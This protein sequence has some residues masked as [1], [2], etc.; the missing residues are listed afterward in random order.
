MEKKDIRK[1]ILLL[2]E[3]LS[4]EESKE[5]SEKICRKLYEM[6]SLRQ[7]EII[8]GYMPIRNEVDIVPLL[9]KL[10][11]EG[12]RLA[13]PRVSGDRM[14]FY[15]INSLQDVVEGSFHVLEP[16]E[17]CRKMEAAGLVLIPGVA[18]D[19]KGG[20]IGYGKGYYDKYFAA[21]NQKLQKIGIGYTIQIVDTI[22]T[23]SLDIPLDGLVSEEGI[24]MFA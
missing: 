9:K 15:E 16:K 12:K 2:R 22:P 1:N 6:E 3:G 5:K 14:D 17:Y 4:K 13:L 24:W 20:R 21:H 23:T 11:K 18:F 19:K 10:L 8:Y 7:A